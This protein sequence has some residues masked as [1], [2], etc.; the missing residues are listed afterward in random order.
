MPNAFLMASSPSVSVVM[1][2]YNYGRFLARALDSVLGQTYSPAEVI[3]VD[4]GST[5]ETPNVLARYASRVRAVRQANRGLSCARNVGIS[6]AS[7]DLVA[8]IDSDDTWDSEKLQRQ[9]ALWARHPDS[10]AIGCGVRVLDA[11]GNVI[12]ELRFDDATAPAR[13]RI[14]CVA[15]R[16][17][18]VGGSGSGALIPAEV[19]RSVGGFDETLGAAED[20]DMWLRIAARFPIRNVPEPL[21]QIWDHRS[22]TFRNVAKLASNQMSVLRKLAAREGPN[23]DRATL[24]RVHA[25][26]LGDAAGE[27]FG[28]GDWRTSVAYAARSIVRW[29]FS[30][31]TWRLL[32]GSSWRGFT[33]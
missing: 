11:N 12:R 15:L 30:M 2:T 6:I 16:R 1:P 26:I 7:G 18:W 5:D 25:L 9:V 31:S 20:W 4:D 13:H 27:A 19:L 21:A 24:R 8:L 3:V 14:R 28:S 23:L 29:P 10:G 17:Q 33:S 32:A 22:G